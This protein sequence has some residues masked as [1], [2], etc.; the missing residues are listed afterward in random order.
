MSQEKD[1]E[2]FRIS[3]IRERPKPLPPGPPGRAEFAAPLEGP[4]RPGRAPQAIE[5]SREGGAP[6]LLQTLEG[7]L[8]GPSQA[9]REGPPTRLEADVID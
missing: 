5:Y 4:P 2:V 9:Q 8:S 1:S 7:P 6:A 3:E